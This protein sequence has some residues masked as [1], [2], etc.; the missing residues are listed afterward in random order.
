MRLD[1][2]VMLGRTTA[3]WMRS[4]SE[5]Q[6]LKLLMN[7]RKRELQIF[8]NISVRNTRQVLAVDEI[9]HFRIKLAF[10]QMSTIHELCNPDSQQ[11]AFLTILSNPP[12]YHRQLK[13]FQSTF[14]GATSWKVEDTWYRQTAVVPTPYN[15]TPLPTNLR[16][17]GQLIDI[18]KTCFIVLILLPLQ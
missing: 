10:L 12:I 15:Q 2:G 9:H 14:T 6:G 16:R 8:F 1:I 13:N 17:S 11:V 4:F 5:A 3:A 7:L 18:G